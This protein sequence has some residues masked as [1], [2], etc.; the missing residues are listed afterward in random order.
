MI[1][2]KLKYGSSLYKIYLYY[3]LYIKEKFYIK[4]KTYSQSKE[5]L[6]ISQFK[7][8]K[9]HTIWPEIPFVSRIQTFAA[10]DSHC[11]LISRQ[12]LC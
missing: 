8:I 2:K 6:F 9:S 5:D 3:H 12:N 1:R 4:R 10:T 7:K 11:V